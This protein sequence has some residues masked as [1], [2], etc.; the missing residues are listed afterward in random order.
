MRNLTI[1]LMA[2]VALAVFGV[3]ANAAIM[4]SSAT[5]P[6]IDGEDIASFGTS[7][8][9]D[10]WW[11]GGANAFGNPGK[12]CG[13]TFT[14][15]SAPLILNA[16]TFQVSGAT[17]PT[18]EYAI[19]VGTVSGTTFTEIASESATQSAATGADAYLTWTLDSPV[20]LAANTTYG[21]DVGLLSSTSDWTTGMPYMYYTADEYPDGSR[22]RSGTAGDGV[23]D[24]DMSHMSGDRVFHLDLVPEP[25]TMAVLALGGLGVLVRRRRRR[26]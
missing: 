23:G 3:P 6:T 9:T 2:V 17:E 8:G 22:F 20:S 15:G 12:T 11:P 16:F 19:R 24:S 25:A 13:Q 18:K 4:T 7:T 26:S 14:T 5:A 21:V 10:K 1:G